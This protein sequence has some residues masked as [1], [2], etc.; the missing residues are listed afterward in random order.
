M[1][2]ALLPPS[3]C[4]A[5]DFCPLL[6][7]LEMCRGVKDELLCVVSHRVRRRRLIETVRCFSAVNASVNEPVCEHRNTLR[8]LH[9]GI[10]QHFYFNLIMQSLSLTPFLSFPYTLNIC[11]FIFLHIELMFKLA[12]NQ[13]ESWFFLSFQIFFDTQFFFFLQCF[14]HVER[15]LPRL[16]QRQLI[17]THMGVVVTHMKTSA[18]CRRS[19]C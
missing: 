17:V 18:D 8:R 7:P 4:A 13:K 3:R 16:N 9:S 1:T 14:L 10:V 15:F 5:A 19:S 6:P 11:E 12:F 2:D